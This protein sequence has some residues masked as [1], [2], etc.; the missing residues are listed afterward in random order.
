MNVKFYH[1]ES[2]GAIA[3]E[4]PDLKIDWK[5]PMNTVILSEKDGC[6]VLLKNSKSPFV[7]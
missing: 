2:E 7:I 1:P 5:L 6:H 4:D 3:W